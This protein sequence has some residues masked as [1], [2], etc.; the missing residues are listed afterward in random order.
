MTDAEVSRLN[1]ETEK[2]LAEARK[3]DAE[4]V[5]LTA[6]RH[7][8]EAEHDKLRFD[9][10]LAPWQMAVGGLAAGGG[11]VA[12]TIALTKLFS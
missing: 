8:L 3:L 9:R 2:L 7:K 10:Q 12:A 11:V 6:E 5:K 4:N 1:A